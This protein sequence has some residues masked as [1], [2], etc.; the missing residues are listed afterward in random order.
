[1][2]GFSSGQ[3]KGKSY[4]PPDEFFDNKGEKMRRVIIAI[5]GASRGYLRNSG[6]GIAARG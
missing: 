1:M 4:S 6:V 5:T 3:Q 2:I